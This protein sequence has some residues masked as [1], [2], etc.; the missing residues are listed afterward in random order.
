MKKLLIIC[1][2]CIGIQAC[3]NSDE[4]TDITNLAGTNWIGIKQDNQDSMF[5]FVDDVNYRWSGEGIIEVGTYTFDGKNGFLND[6]EFETP[7]EINGLK[8][9]LDEDPDN[10][11]TKI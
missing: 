2:L 6:G 1:M 7:F 5:T 11:Y 10:V 4:D 8:M 3:S 9:I